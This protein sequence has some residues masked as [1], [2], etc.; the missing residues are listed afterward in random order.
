MAVN[1]DIQY[2]NREFTDFRNSLI[3]YT[4]TYFPTTYNDFSPASPGML[5][6]EMASYVGD[7][8][9]FY[10]D[11]QVQENYLQFARQTNNL[12]QLAYMFGYKP[13]V[14]GAASANLTFYQKV[15]A[16][17]IAPYDPDYTYALFIPANTIITGQTGI[18]S[19]LTQE[20]VDFTVNTYSDPT[21]VTVYQTNG[22][23]IPTYYLLKK[24]VKA[25]SGGIATS[26]FTF[27]TPQRFAT[28]TIN[29]DNIIG[30]VDA[31]DSDNNNWYEVDYLGQDMVYEPTRNTNINDPRFASYT[32]T[33]YILKLKQVQRRFTTRFLNN[34]T[35]Q[36]QF[37][38]GNT[39]DSDEQ[40]IPNPDNIGIGLPFGQSKLTAAYDPTNFIFTN[41]YGIAPTNTTIT[42][43]YLAGG[44]AGSNVPANTLT[45]I[46]SNVTFLQS[47]LDT[48]T[49]NDIFASLQVTNLEAASGGSD[50]DTVE[51]LRQNS[52]AN[53]NAQLRAVTPDD[54]L[55]RIL[56]LPAKYGSIAK[57]LVTPTTLSEIQAGEIPAVL[58]AYVLAYD[59]TGQLTQCS[60][61]LKQNIITSLNQY[62]MVGDTVKIKD[63]FIINVG[64]KFEIITSPNFNSSEV[65]TACITQLKQQMAIANWQINQPIILRDLY[66]TIE[67]IKGVQ[68]IK[69][70]E[71]VNK[72]GLEAG[73]SQYAYDLKGATLGGVIYPSLDPSIFEVKYPDTDIVG[74][75]VAY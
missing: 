65:L 72:A 5:F 30:I 61:G 68:N 24:T 42:V 66:K 22:S 56:S 23:N 1:R 73:Y 54:Y 67:N 15:P 69:T 6:M 14:T 36:I 48:A 34:N 60:E 29:A 58:D 7:V 44:G 37:G 11:N 17:A 28:V 41:T 59:P 16:Q 12:Y 45:T 32:D 2:L 63:S 4:R 53:F 21:E 64:I 25:V 38:A 26:T 3:N 71:I 46:G 55:I 10:L 39:Q 31:V 33:P 47:N 50:G 57:A 27:G 49:A 70:L 8:L 40:I 13:K 52:I 18:A 19:F 51:E 20:A 75:V 62:R 74:K 35:L 43:R 9:S